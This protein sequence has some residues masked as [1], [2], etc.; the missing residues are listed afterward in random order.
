MSGFGEHKAAEAPARLSPACLKD[1]RRADE[2]SMPVADMRP[3][4]GTCGYNRQLTS[5]SV[6]NVHAAYWFHQ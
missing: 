3:L 1:L 2:R 6:T 4:N 5:F